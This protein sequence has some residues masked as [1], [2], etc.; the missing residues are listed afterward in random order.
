MA[1]IPRANG[2]YVSALRTEDMLADLY[3]GLA[4]QYIKEH[5]NEYK[6]DAEKAAA[7]EQFLK[8]NQNIIEAVSR[9]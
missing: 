8:D 9:S 5:E 1:A 7:R 4:D 2:A 3:N 6:D